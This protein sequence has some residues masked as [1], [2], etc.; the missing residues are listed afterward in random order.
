MLS[1]CVDVGFVV[2]VFHAL[3]LATSAQPLL[4]EHGEAGIH[5]TLNTDVVVVREFLL[6]F[7]T[8]ILNAEVAVG[9]STT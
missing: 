5:R 3:N 7:W 4:P 8:R 1:S 2:S 6:T 9:D